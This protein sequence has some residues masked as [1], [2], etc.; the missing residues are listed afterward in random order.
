[1]RASTHARH[2]PFIA[3]TSTYTSAV[4]ERLMMEMGASGFLRKPASAATLASTLHEVLK[5]NRRHPPARSRTPSKREQLPER[6]LALEEKN[7]AQAEKI[8]WLTKAEDTLRATNGQMRRMLEHSPAMLYGIKWENGQIILRVGGRNMA[9][10]LGFDQT[11]DLNYEWWAGR[12]H[13]ADRAA[14][15]ADATHA[16]AQD[17]SRTE[18][19]LMHKDGSTRWVEDRRQV[20]TVTAGQPMEFTGMW[21]D[22]TDRKWAEQVAEEQHEQ[23]RTVVATAMNA[24]LAIQDDK[25]VLA[26]F[27][28]TRLLAAAT[29][30]QLLG[31]EMS[32]FLNEEDF[33][34]LVARARLGLQSQG[35]L[36]PLIEQ[37]LRRVDG[38]F[39]EVELSSA[40]FQFAGRPALLVEARDLSKRKR[41]ES[42][43]AL[44]RVVAAALS[45]EGS[46]AG[47]IQKVFAAIGHG[48][49]WDLGE[50][51]IIDR[52]AKVLRSRDTW[53]RP[54]I[55]GGEFAAIDHATVFHCG[56]GEPGSVWASARTEW[57]ADI[58]PATSCPRPD[59]SGRKGLQG[60]VGF[61]L[62]AGQEIVGVLGF[63]CR[64]AT[65]PDPELL[66]LLTT[67]GLKIGQYFAR[68]ES[69]AIFRQR[70]K[71]ETLGTLAAGI[72]HDF[73]NILTAIY[74]FGGQAQEEATG[75][76]ALTA[77]LD[78]LMDGARRAT[79][80]VGQILDFSQ[81]HEDAREPIQLAPIVGET[82]RLLR[83]GVPR[84]IEFHVSLAEDAPV[85][86]ADATQIHQ[87]L[88]NL[89]TNAAH[90]MHQQGGQLEM[91]LENCQVDAALAATNLDLRPGR[92]AR[93]TVRDN[94]RGMDAETLARTFEPF[95]T[96]KPP[97][98]GTGLGLSIVHDIVESH[99]GAIIVSSQPGRGTTFQ[100]YFPAHAARADETKIGPVG[101]PR[102]A[103]ERILFVDD[104]ARLTD[105]G[106]QVLDHLG[107][108]TDTCANAERA[109][110]L[111]RTYP[112]AYAL[113]ITDQVMTGMTG[114]DLALR[115]KEIRPDLPVILATGDSERIPLAR[116]HAMGIRKLLVKPISIQTLAEAVNEVFET[117]DVLAAAKTPAPGAEAIQAARTEGLG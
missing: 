91:S 110:E 70:Q 12:L 109:L 15:I 30:E 83:A 63:F 37:Q 45:E 23:L 28:A 51:W 67:L 48:L 46:P 97:G 41:A 111:L 56:Q 24:L 31:R 19:R 32:S 69:A 73:N 42:R 114:T 93:L 87:V 13:P 44:Q 101:F 65:R 62:K 20:V 103:G 71:M 6:Q 108:R 104:E 54:S 29:E 43:L 117:T 95:F 84:S 89:G 21:T 75:N 74:N 99:E 98:E 66:D 64:D 76:A 1:V 5:A 112:R 107:Y 47:I 72:A 85:V 88:M 11:E 49:D 35:N 57:C 36:Q 105:I 33:P 96:T 102:G 82:I 26:N 4:D 113:V 86:L 16:M 7:S 50:L 116:L 39:V 40:R 22:I 92:Y 8:K 53:H 77:L 17:A 55:G 27:A 9:R 34:L 59:L 10:L 14:V 115:V 2:V 90:A 38:S 106:E 25:V 94:G 79:A 100:V 18:Y 78:G 68:L 3:Y 60:W 61:P 80:L 52:K 81:Q 58:S